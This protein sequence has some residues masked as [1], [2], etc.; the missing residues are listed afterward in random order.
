MPKAESLS[1]TKPFRTAT[2]EEESIAVTKSL[3]TRIR[4]A[5][6]KDKKMGISAE[7]E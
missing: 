1:N 2:Q 5:V 7:K 6:K 3:S 4:K